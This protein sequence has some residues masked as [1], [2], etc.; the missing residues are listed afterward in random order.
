MSGK[1]RSRKEFEKISIKFFN[2]CRQR[3]YSES[4]IKEV[5][6]QMESF[7]GYSFSKAHS[8]S[9]AVESFQSLYLKAHFPIEHMVAV[10]NNFGGF[11]QT[12]VYVHEARRWGATVHLPCVNNSFFLTS[13]KYKDV[14]LGFVLIQNLETQLAQKIEKEIMNYLFNTFIKKH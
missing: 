8:A 4:V 7:A 9:Y 13:V 6:R 14:W 12:W 10:L 3:G 2:N 1:Y 5:W 11:Y